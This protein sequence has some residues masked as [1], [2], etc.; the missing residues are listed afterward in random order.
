MTASVEARPPDRRGGGRGMEQR[1]AGKAGGL[2]CC[3]PDPRLALT[4]LSECSSSRLVCS[5]S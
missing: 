3:S 1:H 5:F 4:R 2:G